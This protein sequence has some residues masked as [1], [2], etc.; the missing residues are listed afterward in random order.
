MA[1]LWKHPN[2]PFWTA[3]FTDETGRQ[4]KRSTKLKDQRQAFKVAQAFEDAGKLARSAELT[5]SAAVKLVNELMERT[6]G[7][8]P[9]WI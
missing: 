7:E 8:M 3:C 4:V 6:T 5:R 1:S 9:G 2:S